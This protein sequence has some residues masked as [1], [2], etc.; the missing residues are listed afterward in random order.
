[1]SALKNLE[2]PY[3]T[4]YELQDK[5][6]AINAIMNTD[7]D[8]AKKVAQL[9]TSPKAKNLLGDNWDMISMML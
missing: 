1:M 2:I 5:K 7:A 3:K 4:A 9:L 6:A 8:T